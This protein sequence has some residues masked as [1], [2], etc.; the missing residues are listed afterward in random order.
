MQRKN[1]ISLFLILMLFSTTIIY[2]A[3]AD[4]HSAVSNIFILDTR[5]TELSPLTHSALSNIFILDTRATLLKKD[6]KHSALSNIFTLD[7][8]LNVQKNNGN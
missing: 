5:K 2:I 1:Y 7:T 4:I 6:L 8:L 3:A